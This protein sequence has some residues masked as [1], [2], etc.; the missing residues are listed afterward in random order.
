MDTIKNIVTY[1]FWNIAEYF[2]YESYSEIT[3]NIYIGNI[4]G[5]CDENFDVIVNASTDIPNYQYSNK[6]IEYKNVIVEDSC[7][8]RDLLNLETQLDS[9]VEFIHSKVLE[10][11]KILV[12]CRVG[13]QRS[14]SI[15]AAYLIK[16]HEMSVPMAVYFIKQ[17]R[18][19]AFN[20]YNHFEP[21]LEHYYNTLYCKSLYFIK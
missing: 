9:I 14:C 11:K 3:D 17:K 20:G 1:H 5:S 8:T 13:A 16:Y 12:H 21:V 4:A 6:S 18:D 10:K 15:A 7:K 2:D 19:I